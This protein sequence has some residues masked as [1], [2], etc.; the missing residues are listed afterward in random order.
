VAHENR[1]F[2]VPYLATPP[3]VPAASP[4]NES[5]KAKRVKDEMVNFSPLQL[6]P[7][8]SDNLSKP[9]ISLAFFEIHLCKSKL[10]CFATVVDNLH[11]PSEGFTE[12][13]GHSAAP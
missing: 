1:P 12:Y 11:L 3:T 6:S 5:S 4:V 2:G 13:Q 8:F 9:K 10:W 7:I